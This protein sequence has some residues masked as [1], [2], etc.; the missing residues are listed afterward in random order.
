L[1]R[2]RLTAV[3]AIASA[4]TPT[5][6]LEALRDLAQ[7]RVRL[8][9]VSPER[10]GRAP[11]LRRAVV[12]QELARLVLD[13]AHCGIDWGHGFRPEFRH[14]AAAVEHLRRAPRMALTA[15]ATPSV[16]TDIASTLQMRQ[17]TRTLRPADRPNLRFRIVK[18]GSERER[19]RELLR[20]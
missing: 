7:G 4:T 5:M 8:L 15:T 2:R 10:H 20:V 19:A 13:E 6:R 17:P 14:V 18:V 12:R 3:Q 1:G 11:V 9:Y 16:T